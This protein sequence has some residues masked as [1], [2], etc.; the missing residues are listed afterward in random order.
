M[1]GFDSLGE[2]LLGY[3]ARLDKLASESLVF[4]RGYVPSSL[5]RPSL[6]SMV[7]GLYPHQNGQVGLATPLDW[8]LIANGHLPQLW[9][10]RGSVDTSVPLDELV[11]RSN[12]TAKARAADQDPDFSRRIR[13]GLP[14]A[15]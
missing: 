11:H 3:E 15:R 13:D 4:T 9:Y 1:L 8:R 7:T 10:E 2:L 14:G 12:I 5:C 6:A